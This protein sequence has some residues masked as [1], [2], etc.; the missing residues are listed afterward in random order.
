MSTFSGLLIS[1]FLNLSR[2][3]R[4]TKAL[5]ALAAFLKNTSERKGPLQVHTQQQVPSCYQ[6]S[7]LQNSQQLQWMQD[8]THCLLRKV[9][10]AALCE[11]FKTRL[12]KAMQNR[13]RVQRMQYELVSVINDL[14]IHLE[15]MKKFTNIHNAERGKITNIWF[16]QLEDVGCLHS[17]S[18]LSSNQ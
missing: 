12:E 9:V 10:E 1:V 7:Q 15:I 13:V 16:V 4:L 2:I 14:S 6:W 17:L 18:V 11:W 3:Y 8:L 5:Q